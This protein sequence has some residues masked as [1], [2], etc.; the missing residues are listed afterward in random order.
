MRTRVLILAFL[1]LGGTYAPLAHAATNPSLD[2]SFHIVPSAHEIDPACPEGAPLSFGAIMEIAQ[3][4]INVGISFGV[5]IFTII[6]AWAGFLFIIS[7]VNPEARS[8]AKKMLGNAAIGLLITLTAWLIVDFVMKTLYSGPEGTEGAF[9]P[10]NSILGNGPACVVATTVQP[11]FSGSITAAQL[12]ALSDWETTTTST[13]GSNCPAAPESGMVA[14]SS[15]VTQ[16]GVE[17]ATPET[18]RNFLAM[19]TVA[20][21]ADIDIK[22]S[23]GYRSESEQIFLWNKFCSSGTCGARKVGKPCTLGGN[24]S[25]HNSGKALDLTVG[26][27]NGV[28]NC[29]TKAYNWLKANGSRWSLQNSLPTDPP[30]WSPSGR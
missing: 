3:R 18:V 8:S 27:S 22:V 19:R 12:E 29:N 11:L 25:N 23:D 7:G 1:I 13:G 16:G 17:K 15:S 21:A 28:S 4:F 5:L 20:L 6:I 10:W 30:H 26:C 9:G 24:G 14:F 2:S